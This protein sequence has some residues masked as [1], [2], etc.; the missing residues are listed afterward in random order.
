VLTKSSAQFVEGAGGA[1][2]LQPLPQAPRP[3]CRCRKC[4]AHRWLVS[5]QQASDADR[6][7][8]RAC[9][10]QQLGGDNAALVEAPDAK[11][12]PELGVVLRT[13][14]GPAGP[15][16]LR[17]SSRAVV[18]GCRRRSRSTR[19]WPPPRDRRNNCWRADVRV[20][21]QRRRRRKESNSGSCSWLAI[22]WP[23]LKGAALGF[24]RQEE[25]SSGRALLKQ[26]GG[27]A[28]SC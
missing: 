17:W 19:A 16:P 1:V 25:E 27:A 13:G 23:G 2:A 26:A 15:R 4:P 22:D 18:A 14:V 12:S 10:A 20:S 6:R 3:R 11:P 8:R 21:P 9:P 7:G 28:V 24:A 5:L